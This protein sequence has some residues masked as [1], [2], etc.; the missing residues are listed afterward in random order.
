MALLLENLSIEYG[1]RTKIQLNIFPGA[2]LSTAIVEPYNAILNT[3]ATME[4]SDLSLIYDNESLYD[5]CKNQLDLD[6]PT[7]SE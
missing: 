4:H 3:H 7:Y 5:M 2:T 1:K 6:R